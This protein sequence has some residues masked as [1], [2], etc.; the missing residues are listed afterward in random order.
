MDSREKE[1]KV[2][3]LQAILKNDYG[4][5]NT[6]ELME[7]I[8]KTKPIDIAMFVLQPDRKEKLA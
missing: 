2:K 4:I 7:A 3:A 5:T 1:M 6:A 8:R